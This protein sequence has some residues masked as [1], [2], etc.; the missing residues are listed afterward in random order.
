MARLLV[1]FG[2]YYLG[3]YLPL[4]LD[5]GGLPPLLAVDGFSLEKKLEKKIS[6]EK[7][8]EMNKLMFAQKHKNIQGQEVQKEKIRE[9]MNRE[10]QDGR[11]DISDLS[12]L[13]EQVHKQKAKFDKK[14]KEQEQMRIKAQAK[15]ILQ[16]HQNQRQALQEQVNQKKARAEEG[17]KDQIRANIRAELERTMQENEGIQ[18]RVG[19]QKLV[20]RVVE[21]EEQERAKLE[22]AKERAKLFQDANFR[23]PKQP[24]ISDQPMTSDQPMEYK[25][26]KIPSNVPVGN[27]NR[28]DFQS[29]NMKIQNTLGGE[30]YNGNN[31]G[32]NNGKNNDLNDPNKND[33]HRKFRPDYNINLNQNNA[34]N[35]ANKN[36]GNG[37][38]QNKDQNK[39][40]PVP[41]IEIDL[42]M[43]DPV[44]VDDLANLFGKLSVEDQPRSGNEVQ[45]HHL[46]PKPMNQPMD[47]NIQNGNLGKGHHYGHHS[48]NPVPLFS[49]AAQ[50]ARKIGG[51]QPGEVSPQF[52]EK[53]KMT[54]MIQNKKDEIRKEEMK[55]EEMIQN[56][57]NENFHKNEGNKN[58]GTTNFLQPPAQVNMNKHKRSNQNLDSNMPVVNGN[59]KKAVP[60]KKPVPAP[61]VVR[62]YAITSKNPFGEG[63]YGIVRE[64]DICLQLGN[65]SEN[66]GGNLG[67]GNARDKLVGPGC[68][69]TIITGNGPTG[70]NGINNGVTSPRGVVSPRGADNKRPQKKSKWASPSPVQAPSNNFG[71]KKRTGDQGNRNAIP[72]STNKLT[73][74]KKRDQHLQYPSLKPAEIGKIPFNNAESEASIQLPQ[75]ELVCSIN[76]GASDSENIDNN[77][78]A[79]PYNNFFGKN[80]REGASDPSRY[81]NGPSRYVNCSSGGCEIDYNQNVK[82][83]LKIKMAGTGESYGPTLFDHQKEGEG[84]GPQY[85]ELLGPAGGKQTA[86]Q[87]MKNRD[88]LKKF[89]PFDYNLGGLTR[90]AV[91]G[92]LKVK[93]E[94]G[95]VEEEGGWG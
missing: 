30:K 78:G 11:V 83:S 10:R 55:K 47:Q 1:P 9:Q 66:S 49:T 19:M 13:Q 63:T 86:Q 64:G 39:K 93:V 23:V 7:K 50:I 61:E 75:I 69:K 71:Y 15:A 94:S 28:N 72:D 31:N 29:L 51:K 92:N 26:D 38:N 21:T 57:R 68:K 76:G 25:A 2:L 91:G 36:Y 24:M 4:L 27:T 65:E 34:N 44:P 40:N 73:A 58:Q 37:Q 32:K 82:E 35:N 60:E 22:G 88:V 84:Q 87:M 16:D 5:G 48:G 56:S 79:T 81:G 62:A 89:L 46:N 77:A 74:V 6:L 3:V 59:K 67:L 43:G 90:K 18:K 41:K 85:S 80:G 52:A 8:F 70:N 33:R 95:C 20:D 53:L 54:E 17:V 45:N 42:E 12:K 14:T